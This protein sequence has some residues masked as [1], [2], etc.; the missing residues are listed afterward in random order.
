MHP[1]IAPVVAFVAAAGVLVLAGGR[2]TRVVDRLADV[3]GVGEALAG[4][5]LL[6]ATTSLP[7]L[8]VTVVA[9]AGGE[10][11]LAVSNAFGGIAAQTA[12]LALADLTYRRANLEHAAASVPNLLQTMILIGAIALVLLA[13]AAPHIAGLPVHPVSLVLP[14]GYVLGLALTRRVQRSPLWHPARTAETRV[15]RPDPAAAAA[16]AGAGS[17][18]RLWTSFAGLALVVSACG[19]AI[20]RSGIAIAERTALSGTLV[21]GLFTG[22]ASSLPELVTVLFAVRAGALTLAVGDIIG[23]NTFDVLFVS[24]ADAAWGEGTI[25]AAI[26]PRTQFLLALT[27]LLTAILAAGLIYRDKRG[28]GFE[29]VAILAVYAAGFAALA[30]I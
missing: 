2:F 28:I 7:G 26:G 30:L 29:G 19:Y 10:A 9:A 11:E 4:A 15:D 3:T 5:V 16:A 14:V 6:G 18:A 20:A 13:V 24:A 12:F 8:I 25:Y 27:L 23:G 22:V 17:T 1:L 21:G